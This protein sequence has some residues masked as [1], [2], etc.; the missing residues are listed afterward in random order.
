MRRPL[1]FAVATWIASTFVATLLNG[2]ASEAQD[3]QPAPKPTPSAATST[4][5]TA[6]CLRVS[7]T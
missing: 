7:A 4:S 6:N 2:F 5:S 1:A 3:P